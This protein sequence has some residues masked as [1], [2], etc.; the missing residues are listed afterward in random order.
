MT[1]YYFFLPYSH[2]GG[3]I[4]RRGYTGFLLEDF[5]QL[6]RMELTSN[7][8]SFMHFMLPAKPFVAQ[9]AAKRVPYTA[10]HHC[11]T[12]FYCGNSS[13]Y[14]PGFSQA[15]PLKLKKSFSPFLTVSEKIFPLR[16]EP[17]TRLFISPRV[18]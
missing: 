11:L 16:N 14:S 7:S 6:L 4:S 12:T 1:L 17:A 2:K 5:L 3:I 15:L 18:G 13:Y 8:Y 10:I 9:L